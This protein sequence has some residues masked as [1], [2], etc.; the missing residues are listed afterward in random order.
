MPGFRRSFTRRP[1]PHRRHPIAALVVSAACTA[2]TLGGCGTSDSLVSP[3]TAASV[4]E[5]D[6]V[7]VLDIRTPEEFA[8][9]HLAAARNI[10]FYAA[11]FDEQIAALD[12]DLHYVVYCRS[13]NRSGQA[14]PL[15]D[16]L[17]FEQ[18]TE[19]DGGILAWIAADLPV[20]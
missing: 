5:S 2:I 17:G 19:I 1:A 12:P 7:V 8:E 20:E 6:E 11:D 13:D 9:G 4:I 10:D 16:E 3:E 15:F 18:V 14:M